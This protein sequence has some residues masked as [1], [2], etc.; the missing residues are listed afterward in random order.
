MQ[1][2]KVSFTS[3]QPQEQK[4]SA[5]YSKS[6]YMSQLRGA[7]F[8]EGFL[9]TY[10]ILE[11]IDKF[12][13]VNKKDVTKEVLKK[14]AKSHTKYNLLLG[15]AGGIA[16]VLIGKY[17]TDRYTL[18]FAEKQYDKLVKYKEINNKTKELIKEVKEVG[19]EKTQLPENKENTSEPKSGNKEKTELEEKKVEDKS[20]EKK[21]EEKR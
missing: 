11:T 1:I 5:L 13:L 2:Q 17:F 19:Q 15:L 4:E 16:S 20:S 10:G 3:A 7:Q 6:G 12:V 21:P 14:T 9:A 8:V 18:T